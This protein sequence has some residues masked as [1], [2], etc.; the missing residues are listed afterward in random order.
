MFWI[1]LLLMFSVHPGYFIFLWFISRFVH[2]NVDKKD[3]LPSVSFIIAAYNEE[4]VMR[5]KL[6]NSLNLDYPS[7]KIQ[8]IVAS[9]CSDDNTDNIVRE[10]K[11]KG[12][13]L[14]RLETR[15]GKTA[16]Q[17]NALTAAT[18][19]IL[20]FSD[21]GTVYDPL[22]IKK[23]VRNFNDPGI[24][25]V[26]GRLIH[27]ADTFK[28]LV[29]EKNY[30]TSFE[31]KTKIFESSIYSIIGVNGPIYAVRRDLYRPL[32][33]DLT[34]DFLTP[35]F[36]I[37]RG[38]RAVYEPEAMSFEE[39]PPTSGTEFRRKIRT[40]RAGVTVLYAM[41]SL[42]NPFRY[43]WPGI[44]LV[45]HK[46]S[47]WFFFLLMIGLLISN[48]FV[49]YDDTIYSIAFISQIMFYFLVIMAKLNKSFQKSKIFSIPYFF[50][51][52]NLACVFGIAQFLSGKKSEIWEVER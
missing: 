34:S 52:Y 1:F 7:D 44:F 37:R 49:I 8:I 43:F 31:Q 51:I 29:D 12:I 18:G 14:S 28:S 10:F 50:F 45:G 13:V 35:L 32:P 6:E 36:I 19:E 9:D 23:L 26:G 47:R 15:G 46:L 27:V 2:K 25:C 48:L 41:R 5:Q 30:Y 42:L 16:N 20:V 22:A 40:V 3:F 38:C 21:A 4:K 33:E 17:N 11:D 24:G 39:V